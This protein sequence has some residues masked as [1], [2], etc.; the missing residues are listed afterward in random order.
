MGCLLRLGD[1]HILISESDE[2]AVGTSLV[3]QRSTSESVPSCRTIE[4]NL[5]LTVI[6]KV[7]AIAAVSH[8]LE[9]ITYLYLDEDS[10]SFVADAPNPSFRDIHVLRHCQV[11]LLLSISIMMLL[12]DSGR[13]SLLR[14]HENC[15]GA[16]VTQCLCWLSKLKT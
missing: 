1:Q 12:Y 11:L 7:G 6:T 8:P 3:E 10:S 2:S 16:V 5:L 14:V 9:T 4:F 15:R 13:P